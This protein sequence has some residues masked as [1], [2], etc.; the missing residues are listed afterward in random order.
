[1]LNDTIRGDLTAAMKRRDQVTTGALRM[2]ITS[3][4]NAQVAGDNVREL[5]DDEIVAVVRGE[6]KRRRE[7]ATIYRDAGRIESADLEDAEGDILSKYLPA[8]LSDDQLAE[9][10][11]AAFDALNVTSPAQTGAVIGHVKAAGGAGV[12]AGKVAALVKARLAS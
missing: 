11:D 2:L 12:D 4:S 6:V 5:T 8:A 1:M 10:V 9:L 3:I 7:A